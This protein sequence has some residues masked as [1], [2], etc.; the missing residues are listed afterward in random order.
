MIRIFFPGQNVPGWLGQTE[1]LKGGT[2]GG[3]KFGNIN[4][5]WLWKN[6]YHIVSL[7]PVST[8]LPFIKISKPDNV[9]HLGAKRRTIFYGSIVNVIRRKLKK[10]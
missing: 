4:V 1:V 8:T 7:L 2:P 10:Q 9:F 5:I 3:V 6:E